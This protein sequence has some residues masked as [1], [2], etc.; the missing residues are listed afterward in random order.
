MKL[1]LGGQCLEL[2]PERAL[3]WP[4]IDALVVA[5]VHLGK[6][7][8]FRRAGIAIPATVLDEEL[9]A[10]D[11]LI[12]RW[13]P[14]L[15]IVLGDWVHAPPIAGEAWPERINEWR[16]AHRQLAVS[17][18]PGNH[19]RA[20]APWL[21]RW[22]IEEHPAPHQINGLKLFHEVVLDAPPAG[23]SGHLHPV[24]RVG[25]GPDRLRVPVFAKRG[26]HLV[27]PSFGRFTGGM[28]LPDRLQWRL[29]APLRDRVVALPG[30][31]G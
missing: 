5:D 8:V 12:R 27:L 7:Q 31:R 23:L 18:V 20:L 15:L 19:D 29:F 25:R 26:E 1:D 21:R 30:G 2:L 6:D 22:C 14:E 13:R 24:A 28:E 16:A 11:A 4:A 10:L 9:A 3:R 17:L